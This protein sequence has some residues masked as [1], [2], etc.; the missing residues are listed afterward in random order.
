MI[1]R[2][3][4]SIHQRSSLSK[5]RID[6]TRRVILI[7][8]IECLFAVC[9]SWLIDLILS[10]KY[11]RRSIAISDDCPDFLLRFHQYLILFDLFNSMSN[12][13]L[14][15][16]AGRRFRYECHHLIGLCYNR[17]RNNSAGPLFIH[18][19]LSKRQQINSDDEQGCAQSSS[20]MG[21]STLSKR[22]VNRFYEYIKLRPVTIP[23]SVD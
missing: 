11:C 7:I 9:N 13:L 23:T 18:L 6:E 12:L 3:R 15:C 20:L 19:K 2:V 1:L 16:I 4:T 14:H 10:M 21:Q 5:K 22:H 17:G 8:T